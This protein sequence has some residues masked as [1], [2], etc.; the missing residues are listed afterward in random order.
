[1]ISKARAG[2]VEDIKTDLRGG[3]LCEECKF[4][5]RKGKQKKRLT[6]L[7]LLYPGPKHVREGGYTKAS[8]DG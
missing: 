3:V 4:S 8:G 6:K 5:E 7:M 2:V 1:M